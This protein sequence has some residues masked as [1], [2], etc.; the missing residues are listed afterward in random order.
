LG[1]HPGYRELKAACEAAVP[2]QAAIRAIAAATS[3]VL[4]D[5]IDDLAGDLMTESPPSDPW[6]REG[7]DGA[8]AAG[9]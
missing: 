3:A 8:R 4:D 6:R 2:P 1:P 7:S 5:R 9:F